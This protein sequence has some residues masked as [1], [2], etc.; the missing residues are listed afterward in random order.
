MI[1]KIK[2]KTVQQEV[3]WQ[4]SATNFPHCMYICMYVLIVVDKI[5]HVLCQS[6]HKNQDTIYR[7]LVVWWFVPLYFALLLCSQCRQNP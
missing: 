7:V 3:E 5:N 6:V 4:L 1:V 2:I